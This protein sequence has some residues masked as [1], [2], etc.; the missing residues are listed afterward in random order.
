MC[1]TA[2]LH[3]V[4]L[5]NSGAHTQSMLYRM[6]CPAGEVRSAH[7]IVHRIH[8]GARPP[9]STE[10]Q[11]VWLHVHV[12]AKHYSTTNEVILAALMSSPSKKHTPCHILHQFTCWHWLSQQVNASS[13]CW[14]MSVLPRDTEKESMY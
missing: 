1:T 3:D 7:L 13:Y 14:M 5:V 6:A 8:W 4:S 9:T 10:R 2:Q 12:Q 11:P